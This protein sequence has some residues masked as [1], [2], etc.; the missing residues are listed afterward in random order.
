MQNSNNRGRMG[1][2]GPHTS[3]NKGRLIRDYSSF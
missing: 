2:L 1:R 3:K